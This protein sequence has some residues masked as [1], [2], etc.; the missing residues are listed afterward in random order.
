[1]DPRIECTRR[2]AF[3]AGHRILR[4]ESKCAHLHG[5][6]YKVW[7]T[8]TG[9]ERTTL[10][11]LGRVVDFGVLKAAFAP[12]IE[13]NWDHGFLLWKEDREAIGLLRQL[14]L[15]G[16]RH[17]NPKPQ[18]LF[19]MP[20]APTA[21]NI[22]KYLLERVTPAVLDEDQYGIEIVRIVVQETENCTA[23]VT[24]ADLA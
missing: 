11:K 4:H 10:D 16:G 8:A 7:I 13:R 17:E 12:W 5:H 9:R 2:L 3:E 6:S 21:E 14:R 1:M 19:L 15:G 23:T 18:K 22:A 24:K 20:Y